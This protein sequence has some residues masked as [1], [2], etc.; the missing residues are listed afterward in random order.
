MLLNYEDFFSSNKIL[1]PNSHSTE[2][3][4]LLGRKKRN[5]I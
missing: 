4:K 2:K 5:P 1:Q 3:K